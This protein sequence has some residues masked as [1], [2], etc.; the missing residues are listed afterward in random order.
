MNI[1]LEQYSNAEELVWCQE[2]PKNQGSWFT[3]QHHVRNIIGHEVPLEYAGRPFSA[4]PAVGYPG[5]H[6]QQLEKL[7]SQAIG[8]VKAE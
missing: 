1:V 6:A 2:E 3:S 4:A 8:F 7:I 5:L